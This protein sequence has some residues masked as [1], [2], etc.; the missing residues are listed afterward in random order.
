MLDDTLHPSPLGVHDIVNPSPPPLLC[1]TLE[2]YMAWS[3]EHRAEP[4]EHG[5]R[6]CRVSIFGTRDAGSFL[7][8][9]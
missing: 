5:T 8:V 4:N 7:D 1:R 2:C 3:P 6:C 9:D